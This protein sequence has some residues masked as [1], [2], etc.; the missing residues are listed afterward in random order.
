MSAMASGKRPREVVELSDS[1]DDDVTHNAAQSRPRKRPRTRGNQENPVELS[2]SGTLEVRNTPFGHVAHPPEPM[3]DVAVQL[4]PLRPQS[5]QDPRDKFP[6][7]GA[8]VD[9]LP[10]WQ[11]LVGTLPPE[12]PMHNPWLTAA[13]LYHAPP[14]PGYGDW[15][16]GLGQLGA[17]RQPVHEDWDAGLAPF[18]RLQLP[19]PQAYNNLLNVNGPPVLQGWEHF[20]PFDPPHQSVPETNADNSNHA[21]APA[22]NIAS[23]GSRRDSQ[24]SMTTINQDDCLERVL[25]MFPDIS[26]EYVCGLHNTWSG[27]VDIIMDKI[28]ASTGYPKERDSKAEMLRQKRAKAALHDDQIW[29]KQDHAVMYGSLRQAV[30]YILKNEF[31]EIPVKFI[32]S[33]QSSKSQLYATYLSLDEA[34][35]ADPLPF[36]KVNKRSAVPMAFLWIMEKFGNHCATLEKELVAARQ[37]CLRMRTEHQAEMYLKDAEEANLLSARETGATA[38]W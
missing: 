33:M 29:L 18:Q 27:K 12:D 32:T 2:D 26:H 24:A 6:M 34:W 22:T 3:G 5:V 20:R 28:L 15:A 21:A 1:S 17:L 7:P 23:E 35:H 31:N 4:A 36:K 9:A 8:W 30:L 11:P 38:E 37:E 14:Q 19:V 25:A 16:D 10:D 13:D